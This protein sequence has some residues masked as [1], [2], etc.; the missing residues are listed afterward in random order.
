MIGVMPAKRWRISSKLRFAATASA[1]RVSNAEAKNQSPAPATAM[2]QKPR[3]PT[4]SRSALR[5][6][7]F[8]GSLQSFRLKAE[9]TG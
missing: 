2:T 4:T 3:R 8:I 7:L 5:C 1:L 9:A 6:C